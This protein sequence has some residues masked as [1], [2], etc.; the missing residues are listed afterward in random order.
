MYRG[1]RAA[2]DGDVTGAMERY[3]EAAATM[4]RLGLGRAGAGVFLFGRFAVLVTRDRAGEMTADLER[5]YNIPGLGAAVGEPYAVARAAAGRTAEARAAA[6][7]AAAAQPGRAL[8]VPD[9]RAR[10][11]RCRAG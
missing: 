1:L 7:A 4:T 5:V 3:Q 11:G 8:A 2:V 9:R 10:A 6:R